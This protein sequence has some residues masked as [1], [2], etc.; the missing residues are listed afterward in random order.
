MDPNFRSGSFPAIVTFG[1]KEVA[2]PSPLYIQRDDLLVLQA[3]SLLANEVVTFT[4]RF[5]EPPSLMGGQP[6]D[7]V[8]DKP[9]GVVRTG[10]VVQPQTF[11][12]KP[13]QGGASTLLFQ[14]LGE[15]YLLS[16]ACGAA[17]AVLRGQTFARAV[18]VRGTGSVAQPSLALFADYVTQRG[19]GGWPGGRNVAPEEGQGAVSTVQVSNPAAGADWSFPT[20][21]SVSRV[22]PISF[23]AQ[24]LTSGVAGNRNVELIVDDGVNVFWRTS[25][26]AS[27]LATTTAQISGAT[28]N[29]PTGVVTTDQTVVFPP[30]L[31]MRQGYRLRT[32]TVG[33]V[34]GDQWSNIWLLVEQLLEQ[35]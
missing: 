26:A 5:L 20:P 1:F 13:V 29:A 16:V 17:Q 10:G 12:L 21:F 14:N 15:G 34:A 3:F 24:L 9:S 22:K 35:F 27:I 11:Q 2:P 33:L 23:T 19:A 25:V 8:A 18:M 31:V 4:V 7:Q 28:T 32:N 30:G 6:S